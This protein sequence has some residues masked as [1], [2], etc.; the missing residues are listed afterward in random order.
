[1]DSNKSEKNASQKPV[2]GITMGDINGIGPEVI[3]KTLMDGRV[4]QYMTPV[5]YGS[6]KTLSYY[7]KSLDLPDFNY[8]QVKQAS[9]LI[10]KKVNVV[11]CWDEA[12]EIQVGESTEKA[13]ECSR[14]AIEKASVDLEQG[15]ID[16]IVTAPINK[17]NIHSESFSFAG[18]T[19]YFAEKFG[20]GDSLMM[21]VSN[22]LKI[23]VATTHIP[24]SEVSKAI[25]KE[26]LQKKLKMIEKSMKNDFGVLKPRIAVLGLNP[27][28]GEEGLL[29]KEEQEI[30]APVIKEFKKNGKLVFGPF[31][32]DGFFGSVQYQ[33]YDA[34]LA[35]YHDQG[36]IPFKSLSFD[37]GVNYTAGINAVRTSPDH[38]TAYT[39]AGKNVA[40]PQSMREAI[41]LAYDIVKIKKGLALA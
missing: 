10:Q 17:Y 13:G 31:P 30:I 16:A 14:L 9:T 34:I 29:G 32:A 27:H 2:I 7:R 38:G 1:M 11:N 33:K 37:T 4:T 19:E 26:L 18:H 24:L 21:M 3:M 41:F 23:A 22:N 5:I 36:L 28:S 8:S 25:T 35:M 39:I 15:L 20:E 40:S 6:T 12:V